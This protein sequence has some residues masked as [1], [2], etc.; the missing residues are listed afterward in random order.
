M[1]KTKKKTDKNLNRFTVPR[2]ALAYALKTLLLVTVVSGLAFFV[3]L[4]AMHAS[5]VYI[6]ATEGMTL[7]TSCILGQSDKNEMYEYFSEGFIENDSA[8]EDN[9]YGYYDITNYDYR[10]SVDGISILPWKSTA[11][12]TVTERIPSIVATAHVDAPEAAVPEWVDAQYS[13]VCTKQ[14]N[15]WY[16]TNIK[17]I[18]EAPPEEPNATPDMSLLKTPAPTTKPK[19]T[20]NP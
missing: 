20:E 6:I 19:E 4:T 2:R 1:N 16:I 14:D 7:R 8:F 3:F 9:V 17:L 13:I 11:T 5:N 12:L 10:L 15:R 18:K